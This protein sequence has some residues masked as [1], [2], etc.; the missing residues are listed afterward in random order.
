[1]EV[2]FDRFLSKMF[3]NHFFASF[4][5]ETSNVNK[6]NNATEASSHK[7]NHSSGCGDYRLTTFWS[8]MMQLGSVNTYVF[9][10]K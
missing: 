3:E 1:M 10:R 9:S 8:G 7:K 2:I 4:C 6:L 5:M